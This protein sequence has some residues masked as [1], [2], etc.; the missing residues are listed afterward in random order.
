MAGYLN[1]KVIKLINQIFKT[2]LMFVVLFSHAGII[3]QQ[4]TLTDCVNQA[5][6]NHPDIKSAHLDL[7]SS[8]ARVEQAKSNFYPE[9]GVSVFQSGNFGRSIDRFTNAYI[10]QF[11]NTTYAG[12]NIRTPIFTSFR[13]IHLLA[14]SKF[15]VGSRENGVETAKNIL[16]LS[17][18]TS[19][20]NVLSQS[21]NIRN[22]RNLLKN[23]SIQLKRL[24][25]K[26]A[27]GL[28]T[29]TEEIQ[30]LNQIKSDELAV[31]DAEL[32]YESALI[33]LAQQM[34]VKVSTLG[35]LSPVEPDELFEYKKQNNINEL[36][37]QINELKLR[38]QSQNANIKATQ[39][40][41]YPIIGL[42]A[43]YGTFYASSNP[44]RSFAQQLNDTRN[45]SIS[46][47][48][49]IPIFRG[50]K[51][52]PVIQELKAQQLVTQNS[53][54]KTLNVIQQEL[55]MALTRFRIHKKRFENARSLLDLAKEN[56]SLINDQLE[57]GTV[58]MVDFLLAQNNMERASGTLTMTKYELILQEKI[59]KF[60]SQ[61]K[62]VLD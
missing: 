30:L 44:E 36:L 17:V 40:L 57:A 13:N 6:N 38:L 39:A 9:A 19:Y 15:D 43:D 10:D 34:N 20:L 27:T 14:A 51:N 16:T 31:L 3:A 5:I 53:L 52:K 32:N 1:M 2:F 35:K 24:N 54:D 4:W 59:L 37:P 22:A 48:L 18:I 23:D 50:L 47:I 62:Y 25:I 12:I 28:T 55:D 11:Y 60:Y 8:Q 58:T 46:L 56:M 61:G 21:E 26:K 42:S 49:S 41:S 45:G 33:F 7:G 29:K